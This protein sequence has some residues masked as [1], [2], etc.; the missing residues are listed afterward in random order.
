M[1]GVAADFKEGP[2]KVFEILK[3]GLI[4]NMSQIGVKDIEDFKI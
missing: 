3:K 4:N 1:Y 2:K